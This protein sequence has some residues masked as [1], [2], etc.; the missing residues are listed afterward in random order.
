[1]FKV[2]DIITGLSVNQSSI[3]NSL[4]T[5]EVVAILDTLIMVRVLS[6][7]KYI[8]HIGG[9]FPVDPKKFKLVEPFNPRTAVLRKVAHLRNLFDNRKKE[10]EVKIKYYTQEYTMVSLDALIV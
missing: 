6:H 8:K 10:K 2:G 4:G 9:R 7:A 1:M 5:Y 3:T